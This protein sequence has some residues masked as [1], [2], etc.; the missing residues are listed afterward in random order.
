M[1]KYLWQNIAVVAL[2]VSASVSSTAYAVQGRPELT[3][4]A[5]H[6]VKHRLTGRTR[7]I[8]S[9]PNAPIRVPGAAPGIPRAEAARQAIRRYGPLFGLPELTP[10]A[11]VELIDSVVKPRRR[12]SRHRFRQFF[13]EVPVLAGDLI[14]N[15]DESRDLTSMVGE[16][17][18]DLSVP[19][20]PS[21]DR[22]QA[23]DTAL[24]AVAKWYRVDQQTLQATIPSLWIVDPKLIVT[25]DRPPTLTWRL[26]VT[27]T[28]PVVTIRELIST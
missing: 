9:K 8:F 18:P 22:A 5:A 20:Q 25:S 21:I 27:D 2:S 28:G 1:Q 11:N 4:G 6:V 26:E 19:T 7:G 10:E 17:S 24:T 14:V 3:S 23:R 12:G 16:T 13:R 15:L